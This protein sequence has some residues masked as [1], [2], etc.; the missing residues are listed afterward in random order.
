MAN[1]WVIGQSSLASAA[2]HPLKET[3]MR[4]DIKSR[5]ARFILGGFAL[6]AATAVW[7]VPVNFD[8][9]YE[10][11]FLQSGGTFEG[12][13]TVPVPG[14]TQV[15]RPE[16]TFTGAAAIALT[17][18]FSQGDSFSLFDNGTLIGSTPQVA[19]GKA[20]I[21]GIDP[22][23]ALADPSYSHRI[24][25]LGPGEHFLTIQVDTSPFW[26]G[27]GFFKLA[28]AS[29]PDGGSHLLLVGLGALALFRC[30]LYERF[31]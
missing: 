26:G 11:R 2:N 16:W 29:V 28:Q 1:T 3:E 17:D 23:A 13:G 10:F 20:G 25:H 7:A 4:I 18:N 12:T 15:G 30:F 8:T 5:L 6:C 19:V 21:A 24:F 27:A 22:D 14:T 9:W 31:A